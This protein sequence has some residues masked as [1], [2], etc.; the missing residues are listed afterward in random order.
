MRGRHLL[1][2]AVKLLAVLARHA[3]AE[4]DKVQPP[5]MAALRDAHTEAGGL[6]E[7]LGDL[8][9]EQAMKLRR[10]FKDRGRHLLLLG[11]RLSRVDRLLDQVRE[12]RSLA[13]LFHGLLPDRRRLGHRQRAQVGDRGERVGRERVVRPREALDLVLDL[14]LLNSR[15]AEEVAELREGL[16]LPPTE[17]DVPG[18]HELT[19]FARQGAPIRFLLFFHAG[20]RFFVDGIF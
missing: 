9:L 6:D 18:F 16:L 20:E 3:E 5:A 4:P 10:R 15:R 8:L 11:R 1:A 12:S 7:L 17:S 14:L 19:G 2:E 13:H